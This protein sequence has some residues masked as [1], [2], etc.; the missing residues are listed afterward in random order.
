MHRYAF[1]SFLF[2]YPLNSLNKLIPIF[3]LESISLLIFNMN[4]KLSMD[5]CR[6]RNT[7]DGF[8]SDVSSVVIVTKYF[9]HRIPIQD[10]EMMIGQVKLPFK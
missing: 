3:T 10:M 6:F 8:D 1:L 9:P 2:I 4:L 5:C 7:L